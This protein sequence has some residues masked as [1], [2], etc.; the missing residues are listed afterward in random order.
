MAR[1]LT[2]EQHQFLEENVKGMGNQELTKLINEKFGTDFSLQQI[3]TYKKNHN[4]SS[5]LTGHFPKGHVPINKGTKGMFNVGG[6]KGSFKKGVK[7][8]TTK[9]IGSE[10]VDRKDGYILV[11]VSDGNWVHKHK[12]IWEKENGPI[13]KGCVISFLDGNKT[14]VN[15]DN[16]VLLTRR[17]HLALTRNGMRFKDKELTR[18]GVALTKLNCAIKQKGK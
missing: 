13:P 3:K 16:L 7:P 6:N 9:K 10:R 5:G 1:L 18:A 8:H 11:K 14:N 17:E 2:S 15:I 12:L 4:L